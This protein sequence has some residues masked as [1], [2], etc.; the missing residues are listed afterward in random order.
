[1]PAPPATETEVFEEFDE[2]IPAEWAELLAQHAEF[3]DFTPPPEW[4]DME[5][6][7][8]EEAA[9]A[10]DLAALWSDFIM[11]LPDPQLQILKAIA[12]EENPAG[13]I[14]G[15]AE[16]N[17]TESATL[18]AAI[19]EHAQSTIGRVVIV[20]GSEPPAIDNEEALTNLKQMLEVLQYLEE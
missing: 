20:P 10:E 19:N 11:E 2:E 15:I 5:E 14:Q 4:S 13:T 3:G 1:M 8:P 17:A 12:Q 16:A 9:S 7:Q 18:I 6:Q